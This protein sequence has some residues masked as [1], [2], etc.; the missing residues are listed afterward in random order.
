MWVNRELNGSGA[1]VAAGLPGS[2]EQA[3]AGLLFKVA[4]GAADPD[5]TGRR[6]FSWPPTAMPVRVTEAGAICAGVL[7]AVRSKFC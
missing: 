7:R 6:A 1:F 3:V 2:E 4:D 5:F